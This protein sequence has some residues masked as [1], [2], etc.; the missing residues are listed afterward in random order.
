MTIA[1]TIEKLFADCLNEHYASLSYHYRMCSDKRV[2]AFKYT[3]KSAD[4]TLNP[5]FGNVDYYLCIKYTQEAMKLAKTYEE[6]NMLI[7]IVNFAINILDPVNFSGIFKRTFKLGRNESLDSTHA[8]EVARFKVL[9]HEIKAHL[10]QFKTNAAAEAIN[11]AN[12]N[13]NN[14]LNNDSTITKLAALSFYHSKRHN[15]DSSQLQGKEDEE[16][17]S[18]M[19]VGVNLNGTFN[20][21]NNVNN[22]NP[23]PHIGEA[24]GNFRLSFIDHHHNKPVEKFSSQQGSRSYCIIS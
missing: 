4:K 14:N 10:A 15:N 22:N 17:L 16:D 6:Y 13:G 5:E 7:K 18:H 8:D 1:M 19:T 12:Q 3:I 24:T 21:G 11:S 20:N 9:Q 23:H 2:D